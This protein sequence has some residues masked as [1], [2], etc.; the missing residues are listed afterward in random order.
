V[1]APRNGRDHL[2]QRNT[3]MF[4]RHG[5]R[6][7]KWLVAWSGLLLSFTVAVG[8]LR[9]PAS[10]RP[11]GPPPETFTPRAILLRTPNGFGTTAFEASVAFS[12]AG[13]SLAAG[14]IG[15]PPANG[16]GEVTCTGF[17]SV[18]DPTTGEIRATIQVPAFD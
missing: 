8:M 5:A 17:V 18:W 14:R 11:P 10:P 2:S 7:V 1:R 3:Q 15:E 12:P 13:R 16:P 9:T 6:V 4:S